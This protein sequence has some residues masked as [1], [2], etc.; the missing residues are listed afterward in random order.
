MFPF[1]CLKKRKNKMESKGN[2]GS[3]KPESKSFDYLKWMLW[4]FIFF[5]LFFVAIIAFSH[6]AFPKLDPETYISD[7]KEI[8]KICRF[9]NSNYELR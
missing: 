3:E 5:L 1:N 8:S 6:L 4:P 2:G 9:M 7:R